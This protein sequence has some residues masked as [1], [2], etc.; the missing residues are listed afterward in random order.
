MASGQ[1][2]FL[3][4]LAILMSTINILLS[5]YLITTLEGDNRLFGIP[6]ATV[7]VTWLSMIIIMYQSLHTLNIKLKDAYAWKKIFTVTLVSLLSAIPVIAILTFKLSSVII[8]LLSSITYG[9]VFLYIS[10]K[11]QLWG[12]SEINILKSFVYLKNS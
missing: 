6:F 9:I 4:R 3:L 10:F 12:E 5:Y 1:T 7:T 2:K 8:L 11:L